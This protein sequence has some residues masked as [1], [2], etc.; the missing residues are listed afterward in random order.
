MPK[1]W[2]S[3]RPIPYIASIDRQF[4]TTEMSLQKKAAAVLAVFLLL[5]AAGTWFRQLP[6]HSEDARGHV[7]VVKGLVSGLQES[8]PPIEPIIQARSRVEAWAGQTPTGGKVAINLNELTVVI[9]Q[10]ESTQNAVTKIR[11]SWVAAQAL[12][13]SHAKDLESM[14]GDAV[15]PDQ[16]KGALRTFKD[17]LLM[18]GWPVALIL[19]LAYILHSDSARDRIRLLAKSV[20]S[21]TLPGGFAVTLWGE[22]FRQD[23]SETFRKFRADVQA[24]YDKLAERHT[25]KDT[26]AR[27]LK[28]TIDPELRRIKQSSVDYRATIH[29]RD[30]L[31]K[32]SY[33]QLV[34]Y[35]PTGGNRGRAWS[36][37][38]GM[39][40]RAWRL[41]KD[42][43]NGEVPSTPD[44][45]IQNWG[46]TRD[47]AQVPGRQTMLCC[48]LKTSAGSPV[49]ALYLDA[50]GRHEF[51]SD[52]EMTR[53]AQTAQRAAEAAGLIKSLEAIWDDIK[54]KA[55]L[56]EVYGNRT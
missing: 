31:F 51:G 10:L 55:P 13:N 23:Q 53:L 56:V 15:W 49:A 54:R 19:A 26:L 36:M 47:E 52:N 11:A 24:E 35:L 34:D 42:S 14:L 20:R 37:R 25:I 1:H 41:E 32:N 2:F 46:M 3:P 28:D 48:I 38:F 50:K 17:L 39:V 44:D 6:T 16:L 5:A 4:Y 33:Y 43:W 40:G 7:E 21:L 18:L 29:V 45:L 8:L 9:K 12:I 22:E 27:I 30:A